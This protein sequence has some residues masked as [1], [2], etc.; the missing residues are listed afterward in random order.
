MVEI[1]MG[2][3][4]IPLYLSTLELVEIQKDI[5]CTVA[6]LK[7]EVFG[8]WEDEEDLDD[9]GA[10]KKKMKVAVDPELMK[11]LGILIRILGNA[12]LE[13]AGQEA[14]LTDKWILRHMKPGLIMGYAIGALGAVLE[15]MLTE[16][17]EIAG[18]DQEKGPVDVTIEESNRKK[19]PEK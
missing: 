18:E 14:N 19:E 10:P 12:G 16:S 9:N 8:L 4:D 3:R 7:D 17:A 13:E 11:R 5:G 2:G 6:Q 15:G 1:K